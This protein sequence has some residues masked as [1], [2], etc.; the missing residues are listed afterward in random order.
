MA[1]VGNMEL[2]RQDAPSTLALTICITNGTHL[3]AASKNSVNILPPL[4]YWILSS[5]FM[6]RMSVQLDVY[7]GTCG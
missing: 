2:K 1:A 3:M 7:T 5:R 4:D 6:Q